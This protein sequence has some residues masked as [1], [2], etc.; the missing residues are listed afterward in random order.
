MKLNTPSIYIHIYMYRVIYI[1]PTCTSTS[2]PYIIV[3]TIDTP[4]SGRV[5][6]QRLSLLG[7]GGLVYTSSGADKTERIFILNTSAP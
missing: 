3:N 6:D 4:G 1:G 7:L 5:Y 2:V